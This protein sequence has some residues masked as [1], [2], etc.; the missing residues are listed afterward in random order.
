M[1]DVTTLS[2][3]LYC[4]RKLFLDKVLNLK[5]PM[6]QA[7]LIGKIK[8]VFMQ[9]IV[10]SLEKLVVSINKSDVERNMIPV[11]VRERFTSIMNSL[12]NEN[13]ID[14][15]AH[16]LSL[17]TIKLELELVMDK[18]VLYFS[19]LIQKNIKQYGVYS[20][21]LWEQ[22][23]PKFRT[24]IYLASKEL[25]LKG[26]IDR[27][28]I[29]SE[30]SIPLE[31]KFGKSN[32]I[33]DGYKIQ[34]GAYILLLQSCGYASGYGAVLFPELA[35]QEKISMNPFLKH[36]ITQLIKKATII[37]SENSLPSYCNNKIKC[38]ACPFRIRCYDEDF[39][40]EEM[41]KL[42]KI[43]GKVKQT[44]ALNRT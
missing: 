30:L 16:E 41:R 27:L 29:L 2:T 42:H 40:N 44:K 19:D 23:S 17:E 28:V 10:E 14:I 9:K 37:L 12:I 13:K 33:Y 4:P 5:K 43:T 22:F 3:Y 32:K 35:I 8:H 34:I 38:N 15:L 24:E 6:T 36:E 25:H 31:F 7:M 1:I 21:P 20:I 18:E 11:K 26:K 39:I